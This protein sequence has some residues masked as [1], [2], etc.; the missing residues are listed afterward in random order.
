MMRWLS[1]AVALNLCFSTLKVYGH[2]P[3][4]SNAPVMMQMPVQSNRPLINPTV[5]V[6]ITAFVVG[7]AIGIGIG[8]LISNNRYR[9]VG[10]G[11]WF[12]KRR[13][14]SLGYQDIDQEEEE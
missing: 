3:H 2:R 6:G 13:R 8:V 14:R 7:T 9:G 10:G 12:G 1:I 11:I 4:S 5:C